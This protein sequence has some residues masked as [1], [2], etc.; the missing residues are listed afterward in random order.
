MNTKSSLLLYS[1]LLASMA[2]VSGCAT[3]L[4][5]TQLPPV[6]PDSGRIP[7]VKTPG[8]L[9]V[10]TATE[11]PVNTDGGVVYYPHTGYTIFNASGARVRSVSN[12]ISSDDESPTRVSL[13]P[14]NY[15]VRAESEIDGAVTVPVLIKGMRTTVVNL[16]KRSHD[17]VE[18]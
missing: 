16:E 12:H 4:K 18:S 8:Y 3:D 14:G 5:V 15:V 17:P 13:P 11:D 10:Y 7:G 6:G 9:I 1:G 2:L